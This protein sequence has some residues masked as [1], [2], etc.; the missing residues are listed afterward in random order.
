MA[1]AQSP[2]TSEIE[3]GQVQDTIL[4]FFPCWPIVTILLIDD[5]ENGTWILIE[6]VTDSVEVQNLII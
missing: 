4:T 2:V 1:S 6:T 3:S 5:P